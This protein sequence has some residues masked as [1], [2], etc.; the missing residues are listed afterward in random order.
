MLGADDVH[1]LSIRGYESFSLVLT[2]S[3]GKLEEYRTDLLR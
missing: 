2:C 3:L 1:L